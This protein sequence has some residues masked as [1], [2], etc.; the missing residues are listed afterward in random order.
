M[1]KRIRLPKFKRISRTN[2]I[3]ERLKG[4]KLRKINLTRKRKRRKRSIRRSL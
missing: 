3:E 2:R 1:K 4:I